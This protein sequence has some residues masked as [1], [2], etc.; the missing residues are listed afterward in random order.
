[1]SKMTST[2]TAL[3]V[4][5][6]VPATFDSTGYAALTWTACGELIDLPEFGPTIQVVESNPLATGITEKFPGFVNQGSM[7]AGFEIDFD[8]AGQIILEEGLAIPPDPFVIHSF[9]V[10]YPDG[11]IEYFSGGIFSYTRN[12]GSANSMI[13]STVQ[14][15]INTKIVR[16]DAP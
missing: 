1:V 7:S 13:G 5:A 3:S 15:E 6:A 8:D 10:A 4:S 11:T 9:R 12:P 2:G 14:I 16:V